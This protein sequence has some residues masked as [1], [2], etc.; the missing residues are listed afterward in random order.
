M[1]LAAR[2]KSLDK[3]HPLLNIA[4]V[5]PNASTQKYKAKKRT[6]MRPEI[7]MTRVQRAYRQL[8]IAE[9]A[10]PLIK[11]AYTENL[12]TKSQGVEAHTQW[13]NTIRSADIFAFSDGSSEGHGRYAW[14]FVHQ[15]GG[16]IIERGKGIL[17]GGEVFDAE[18]Y[19]ATVA[20]YAALSA[21]QLDRKI[22]ILFDN[23][24][25]VKAL[26][27]GKS[28]SSLLL[29]QT[30]HEVAKRANAEVRWVPGHSNIAGNVEA[31]A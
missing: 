26:K 22:F 1:R 29:T 23:Q 17:H 6:S 4:S 27:T 16:I 28:S 19:G 5:C 18:L 30:F 12:G 13:V 24:A 25:A 15:R 21:R 3:Q 2:L 31:D 8:P 14:G 11:P 20:F 7:H 10:E 9:I